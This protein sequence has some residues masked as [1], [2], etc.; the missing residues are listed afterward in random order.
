[1]GVRHGISDLCIHIGRRWRHGLARQVLHPAPELQGQLPDQTAQRIRLTDL[2]INLDGLYS[3]PTSPE[4]PTNTEAVPEFNVV[5]FVA[6]A[7][8]TGASEEC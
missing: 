2:F 8:K 7:S 1:M 5:H 6:T 4:R 3:S